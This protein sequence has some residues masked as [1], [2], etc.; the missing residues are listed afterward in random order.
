MKKGKIRLIHL[1][2]KSLMSLSPHHP[3][4]QTMSFLSKMMRSQG[5]MKKAVT[6]LHQE[7]ELL[8]RR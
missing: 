8:W 2:K 1:D 6:L 5:Q 4:I 3:V 7:L